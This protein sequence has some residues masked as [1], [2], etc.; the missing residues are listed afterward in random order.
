LQWQRIGLSTPDVVLAAT[1]SYRKRADHLRRFLRECVI[2]E[3]HAETKSS[4]VY[5]AYTDWCESN[6]ERPLSMAQFK[7]QLEDLGFEHARVQSGSVWRQI[8]LRR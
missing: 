6:H 8:R 5:Q 1:G 3:E 7:R 2:Q 4:L